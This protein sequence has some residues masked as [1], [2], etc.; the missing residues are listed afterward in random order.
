VTAAASA[1]LL[2]ARRAARSTAWRWRRK[3]CVGALHPGGVAIFDP[4]GAAEIVSAPDEL[5]TNLCFGGGEMR[6]AVAHGGRRRPFPEGPLA[7]ARV[8]AEL[9]RLGARVG[10]SSFA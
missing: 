2:M 8:A 6:D 9:Q 3:V 5:I 10:R 4:D 1:A 7:T